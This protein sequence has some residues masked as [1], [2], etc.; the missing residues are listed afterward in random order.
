M[1]K[2]L[3]GMLGFIH[4]YYESFMSLSLLSRKIFIPVVLAS[5]VACGADDTSVD[6]N[7]LSSEKDQISGGEA[8][9]QVVMPEQITGEHLKV[10]LNGS[11]VKSV[12]MED[13]DNHTLTGVITGLVEGENRLKVT[14]DAEDYDIKPIN[15]VLTNHSLSGPIFS[16]PQ[17]Q[18]FYCNPD[19]MEDI[20]LAAPDENCMADVVVSFKYLTTAGAWAEYT[21]GM[22]RP[23]DMSTTVTSDGQELDFVVRWERGTINRFMYSIAMLSSD[24]Q[25]LET[26]DLESWNKKLLFYFRGGTAIGHGQGDFSNRRALYVEGLKRGYAVAFSTGTSAKTH[27]NLQVGGETALMLKERFITEYA[28]PDYT[29]AVG[30]SGGAIQ[31]YLYS[32]NHK[33]LLDAIIP[34]FSYPDMLSQTI[35]AG[36]CGLIERWIDFTLMANPES[37]WKDW[38]QR[39]LVEGMNASNDVASELSEY[40]LVHPNIPKGAS[41]CSENWNS[42]STLVYNPHYGTVDNV[43]PEDQVSTEWTHFGDAINVYEV[44]DDGYA[45]RTW[46]NVGVQYGLAAL[47]DGTLTPDDFIDLNF[48]AGTWK[49][50]SDMVQEGCPYIVELCGALDFTKSLFPEQI[51][52]WAARNFELSDG[53]AP[54]PRA[55]ADPGAIENAMAA[56]FVNTGDIQIP[57]IDLRVNLETQLD[58]H[59][60]IQSFVTRQR[61]IN[62]DG[63]ASNQVI[64]FYDPSEEGDHYDAVPEALDV[65]DD[66]MSNMA[67][68]PE[69]SISANK[70]LLA[71][72]SCFDAEGVLVAAGDDVWNG[73]LDES[74]EKGVCTERNKTY[75]NSRMVAGAP[76]SNDVF[77]CGLQPITTALDSGLYGEWV[78]TD[79]QLVTLKSIFPEGVCKF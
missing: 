73:I 20:G 35:P 1:Y 13:L 57:T 69:N 27:Y 55:T 49:Q 77:K 60:T 70:P 59:N 6:V 2:A 10:Q 7:V 30:Q 41:E 17:Q 51:D 16:G 61:L 43:S 50:E 22:E 28:V 66:W 29:V 76:L 25:N 18:P 31:Q 5:L 46:D 15:V 62:F 23:E 75:T 26:P 67:A 65:M 58:M 40:G 52:P 24:S 21:Q 38:T 45:N 36:D 56:G 32:Q 68:N 33:G 79:E 4:V 11:D 64:W 63:D 37:H 39:T 42:L 3:N 74:Q 44:A 8:R 47:V 53:T 9:I 14:S 54:A 19:D 12:L 78:P 34:S 72:D 48:H 71:K